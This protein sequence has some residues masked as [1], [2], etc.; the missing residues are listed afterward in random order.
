MKEDSDY[1]DDGEQGSKSDGAEYTSSGL[2]SSK[3]LFGN[4]GSSQKE[5]GI[6]KHKML[7]LNKEME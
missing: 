2:G 5:I 4:P 7:L 1:A 3:G 6:L